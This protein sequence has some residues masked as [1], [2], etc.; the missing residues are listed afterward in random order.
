MWVLEMELEV[1]SERERCAEELMMK[2]DWLSMA[3]LWVRNAVGV[4][5]RCS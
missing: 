5:S 2:V 1:Q 4:E 3:G